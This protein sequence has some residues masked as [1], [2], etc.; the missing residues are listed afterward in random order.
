MRD[1]T[2]A[3]KQTYNLATTNFYLNLKARLE[4]VIE[5]SKI[6]TDHA[7]AEY[8]TIEDR[9]EMSLEKRLI[10]K[11]KARYIA[12]HHATMRQAEATLEYAKE[13]FK[14]SLIN[15]NQEAEELRK[16]RA[17]LEQGRTRY[18]PEELEA[19]DTDLTYREN[20]NQKR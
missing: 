2:K 1:M 5:S 14:Q 8:P 6:K 17:N 12:H 19:W 15:V 18:S 7:L 20:L 10:L 4:S 13:V 9:L 3:E 11:D 16:E